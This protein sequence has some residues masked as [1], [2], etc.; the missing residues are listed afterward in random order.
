MRFVILLVLFSTSAFGQLPGSS[1]TKRDFS[2][3]SLMGGYQPINTWVGGKLTGS[4]T[5]IFN[6][7]LSL[8]LEYAN[9]K[10]ELKTAGVE[11][12]DADENRYTL[13]FK[14]YFGNSFYVSLGSYI[15]EINIDLSKRI[16]EAAGIN[17]EDIKLSSLGV[18]A[19]I[20]NRWQ[21]ENGITFGIDWFRIN[22]PTRTYE[23]KDSALKNLQE[24]DKEDVKRAGK[25]LK[26]MPAI[27]YFG[28]NL[29]YTF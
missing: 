4:Y 29:G 13:M 5:H 3:G 17:N 26:T 19:G 2:N 21:F 16:R 22:Q 23:V 15:N 11:V 1:A 20:G 25:I 6:K 10:K 7:D 28:I 8:E 24:E 12:G 14:Y 9:S 27:T 18:V